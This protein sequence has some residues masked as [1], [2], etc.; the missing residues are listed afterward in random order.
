MAIGDKLPVVM[1]AEKAT[2]GGVATL[3]SDGI[4]SESQRPA[5]TAEQV[6][7]ADL[8]LSNLTNPQQALSNLG[9]GVRPNLADNCDFTNPVNTVGFTSGTYSNDFSI[10]NRW[11]V[12]SFGNSITA[13]LT[14]TGLQ[15]NTTASNQGLKQTIS[16]KEISPQSYISSVIINGVLYS[17]KLDVAPQGV[18]PLD[19]V[20]PY[21]GSDYSCALV[22]YQGDYI[23]YPFVEY[24][25][26]PMEVTISHCKLEEGEGQTLAYEDESGALVILPQPDSSYGVR[27]LR[28]RMHG[29][30]SIVGGIGASPRLNLLDNA[31]FVGGGSQQGGGQ[32]PINQRGQTSYSGTLN[33]FDRWYSPRAD[34]TVSLQSDGV[35][36]SRATSQNSSFYQK[37][38]NRSQIGVFTFSA[39]VKGVVGNSIALQIGNTYITA[40]YSGD[41]QIVQYTKTI[42]SP[43]DWD[44]SGIN[45]FIALYADYNS[46]SGG[47]TLVAAAKLEEGDTQTLAYQDSAGAWKLLPQPDMKYGAQL[48]E[49]QRFL[50]VGYVSQLVCVADGDNQIQMPILNTVSMRIMNPTLTWLSENVYAHNVSNNE[51]F[52]VTNSAKTAN[53]YGMLVTLKDSRFIPGNYYVINTSNKA[54]N[55]VS[56]PVLALMSA[57]L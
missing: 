57:E 54:Q 26:E 25:A 39:L 21:P 40:P 29:T 20:V 32:L 24:Q 35:L 3:G 49:C 47:T 11:N 18:S 55:F 42:N 43:S 17:A 5:Y 34:L 16:A 56:N 6:K 31:Y 50:K 23:W 15:I 48:A 44:T 7:A 36:L 46:A 27:L 28:C 14:A 12:Q 13:T 41:W 30:S 22:Q 19:A 52:D 37:L 2:P 38:Q 4:L 9:A 45:G 1:G 53:N 51:V 10:F 8:T 33:I